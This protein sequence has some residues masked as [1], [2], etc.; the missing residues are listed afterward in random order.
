ML[1]VFSLLFSWESWMVERGT[2]DWGIGYGPLGGPS[3]TV[4]QASF[5]GI[6]SSACVGK[7]QCINSTLVE[8]FG[9][10]NPTVEF[11]LDRG[12]IFGVSPLARGEISSCRHIKGVQ[13]YLLPGNIGSIAEHRNGRI[14]D[15]G[16]RCFCHGSPEDSFALLRWQRQSPGLCLVD[17]YHYP[18]IA[19]VDRFSSPSRTQM[20]VSWCK[21]FMASVGG[22]KASLAYQDTIYH[23]VSKRP[24]HT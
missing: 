10:M 24:W 22:N 11:A 6:V 3:D 12:P 9:E 2:Y 14:V 21:E 13:E 19:A 1:G 15:T 7:K 4:I 8:E 23:I 18:F 20:W 5:I 16:A 17:A